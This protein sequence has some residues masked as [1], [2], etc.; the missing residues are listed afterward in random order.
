[1]IGL[2]LGWVGLGCWGICFWWMHRISTRQDSLLQELNDIARRIERFSK[3]EHEMI[4]EVH[5]AVTEIKER[6][7]DVHGVVSEERN[8]R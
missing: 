5:P 6:M 7:E 2:L 8:A 3:A 4:K 1:M